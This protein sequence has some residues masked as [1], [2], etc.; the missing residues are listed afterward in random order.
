MAIKI[1]LECQIYLT[2]SYQNYICIV[3]NKPKYLKFKYSWLLRFPWL[4]YSIKENGAFC[5]ICVAFSKSNENN[6]QNLGAL[7]KKKI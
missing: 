2:N 6:G 4:V 3:Q 5:R 1:P 7:V